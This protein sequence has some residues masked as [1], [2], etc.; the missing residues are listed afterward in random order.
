MSDKLTI[1]ISTTD[2]TDF[3]IE[4]L[5][6]QGE[7][8]SQK[9]KILYTIALAQLKELFSENSEEVLDSLLSKEE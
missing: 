8:F 4:Q 9:Q 6:Y 1:V 2:D 7:T 3:E 5:S